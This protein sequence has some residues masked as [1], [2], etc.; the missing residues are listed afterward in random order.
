[1]CKSGEVG[2]VV[3]W[4]LCYQRDTFSIHMS[5][6]NNKQPKTEVFVFDEKMRL[7]AKTSFLK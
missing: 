3:E 4:D 1:M 2:G 5:E 7:I 6:E